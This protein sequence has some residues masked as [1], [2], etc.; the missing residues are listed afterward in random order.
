[1]AARTRRVIREMLAPTAGQ[2]QP[3][4]HAIAVTGPRTCL[5]TGRDGG[6]A[7]GG[8]CRGTPRQA[9]ACGGRG[10][11][12]PMGMAWAGTRAVGGGG[13]AAACCHVRQLDEYDDGE[14]RRG[15]LQ[16]A[17]RPRR[18]RGLRCA[19]LRLRVGTSWVL[20]ARYGCLL[21]S[22][23]G[24]GLPLPGHCPTVHHASL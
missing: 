19:G 15:C 13:R 6:P 18:R 1:M 21:R 10:R 16:P 11:A 3:Q 17:C 2:S 23:G 24:R 7:A 4:E 14:E 22:A 12:E 5:A 9:R 8:C 20:P